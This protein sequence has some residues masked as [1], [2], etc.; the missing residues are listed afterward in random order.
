MTPQEEKTIQ[1]DRMRFTKNGLSA[2]LVYVSI[3]FDVLFFVSIYK[4][5]VGSW[6]Y[7][8]L[9]G[10]SVLYNLV[11]MLT[12]FLASEGIKNYKMTFSFVLLGLG[13]I[14]IARIFIFP[15]MAHGSTVALQGEDVIVMGDGQFIRCVIYLL[16]SAACLIISAV[17]GAI[18]S[19]ALAE[20]IASLEEKAA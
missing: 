1:R 10:A 12:A 9:I 13:V 20:H 5:D 4:S 2:T 3:L 19:R 7:T 8:I 17:I 16:A 6:Y 15:M 14:Q 18:R 11:F